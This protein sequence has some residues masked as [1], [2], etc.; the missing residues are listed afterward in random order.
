MLLVFLEILRTRNLRQ[1]L[2]RTSKNKKDPKHFSLKSSC[3]TI[4]PIFASA[5]AITI[6]NILA[7]GKMRNTILMRP[8][9]QEIVY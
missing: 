5:S 3:N 7:A 2:L 4:F 6:C 8:G 9:I 1:T